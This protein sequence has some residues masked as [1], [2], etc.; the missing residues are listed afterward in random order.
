MTA[1]QV[2]EEPVHETN[3]DWEY[4]GRTAQGEYVED[5][6]LPDDYYPSI[7]DNP[8]EEEVE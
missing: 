7:L 8:E 4:A 2:T 1:K 5:T 3:Y 6:E